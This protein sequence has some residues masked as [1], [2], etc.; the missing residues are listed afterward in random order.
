MWWNGNA[1]QGFSIANGNHENSYV[2]SIFILCHSC[3]LF[4]LVVVSKNIPI[5]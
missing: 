2:M 3:Y 4:S 5:T 1:A